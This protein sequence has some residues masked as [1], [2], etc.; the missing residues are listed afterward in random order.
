MEEP[1]NSNSTPQETEKIFFGPYEVT[2]QVFHL[3]PHTFAL[4]NLKPLLPG[5]VLICP[6]HPHTRLTSLSPPEL[7]D[8]WKTVQLI[9]KMLALHYFPTPSAGSFNIA[10]QDGPEAGQTVPHVHVHVIP[11]IKGSTGKEEGSGEGDELYEKMAGEDGNI[12]GKLWD[13]ERQKRPVAGKGGFERIEEKERRER[14][15]REMEEEAGVYRGL[16]RGL[17]EGEEGN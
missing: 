5:H 12:G 1:N 7:L 15:M 4:V 11:R 8:L 10:V 17:L 3:T 2:T 6:R 16:L 13:W 14:G 9:Q